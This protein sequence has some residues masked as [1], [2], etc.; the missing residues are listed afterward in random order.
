MTQAR[1]LADGTSLSGWHV[2][3]KVSDRYY[4]GLCCGE[5]WNSRD[6][7][8]NSI[9]QP[10]YSLKTCMDA[11]RFLSLYAQASVPCSKLFR[12]CFE[13]QREIGRNSSTL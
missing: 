13:M 5:N 4:G 7:V 12:V 10:M 3:F 2:G 1:V 6:F 11:I 8:L 9:R